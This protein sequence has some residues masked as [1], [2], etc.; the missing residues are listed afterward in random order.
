MDKTTL[1]A[2]S[3]ETLVLVSNKYFE[4]V[5]NEDLKN[6]ILFKEKDLDDLTLKIKQIFE[7]NDEEKKKISKE[8]REIVVQK[9]SLIFLVKEVI[10]TL[11]E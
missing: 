9:H 11:S 2:M 1:E 7:L 4:G 3:C 8:L 5:L 10:K 6:I